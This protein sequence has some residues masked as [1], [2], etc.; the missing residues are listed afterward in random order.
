MALG[1]VVHPMAALVE[2]G[3]PHLLPVQPPA[4]AM[5]ALEDEHLAGLGEGVGG[6]EPGGPCPD[7]Y[8]IVDRVVRTP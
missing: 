2:P 3:R 6:A 7:H 8:H 5:P 1:A 4:G